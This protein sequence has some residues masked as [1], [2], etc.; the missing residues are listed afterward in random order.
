MILPG[1]DRDCRALL[2]CLDCDLLDAGIAVGALRCRV[3]HF[4]FVP[5]VYD[6]RAIKGPHVNAG[7]TADRKALRLSISETAAPSPA[8]APAL[9]DA[10]A[11]PDSFTNLLAYLPL[12]ITL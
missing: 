6:H 9:A 10:H 3:G 11:G 7:R 8:D 1:N 2:A 12:N 5:G 4:R